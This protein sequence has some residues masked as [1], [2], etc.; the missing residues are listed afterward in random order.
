MTDALVTAMK[1]ARSCYSSGGY[2]GPDQFIGESIN[3]ART[4]ERELAD[5]D[6]TIA[7]LR[8]ALETLDDALDDTSCL[9]RSEA[10][11][12]IR[13]TLAQVRG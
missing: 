2:L 6:A 11:D 9:S 5:R 8:E 13:A 4:L 3:L 10:Q 7:R 1:L 12:I